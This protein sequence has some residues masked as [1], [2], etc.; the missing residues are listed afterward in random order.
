MTDI[1]FLMKA[2]ELKDEKRTGWEVRGVE[3]PESVAD[4]SWGVAFLSFLFAEEAG[5]DREKA[6]RMGLLHDLH[7]SVSGDIMSSDLSEP[8]EREKKR[9]EEEGFQELLE[10]AEGE[11]DDLAEVREEYEE[12]RTE[13]ARFVKDM[14]RLETALQALFYRTNERYRDG[15]E[16]F[17][18]WDGME[19]FFEGV[20][21]EF[22]T[23]KAKRVFDLLEDRYEE[24]GD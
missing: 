8:E 17:R 16:F 7:E 6:V 2:M 15:E 14:D 3:E 9:R 13:T 12:R 23:E 24:V 11:R 18:K 5:T 20:R 19:E 4:H 10:L 22:D 1:D 21:E